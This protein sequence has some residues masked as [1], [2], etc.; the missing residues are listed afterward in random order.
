MGKTK[1]GK[2]RQ[3]SASIRKEIRF[4]K[5]EIENSCNEFSEARDSVCY[6]LLVGST[7]IRPALVDKIFDELRSQEFNC[8][9]LDVIIH[10]GGGDIDAAYN[11]ALLFRRY[12]NEN[13]TFIIPRWAKS[14]ATLLICS[15]NEILMTPV[16]EIGP[17]D[18]QI[19]EMNPLENRLERFSPLHIESTLQLIRDEFDSGNQD[20]AD[21]LLQRLQF[22]MTLGSFRKSL[23]LG[24]DYL[25][26][27]LKS[28]MLEENKD[29]AKDIAESLSTGYANHSWCITIEEAQNLGLKA[30]ELTGK[31]LDLVWT[32]YKHK[33]K[34]DDLRRKLDKA[35]MLA[36][37]KK[38]PPELLDKLQPEQFGDL[39]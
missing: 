2:S 8:K 27:L 34:L 4:I 21:G 7:E 12:G 15:G 25:E 28:R 17:L 14:A 13:L 20:L 35:K 10:S 18:P 6:P 19:T 3:K 36:E 30:K 32:I 23:D 37:L 33:R 24:K 38:L 29:K 22:P 39:H 1:S 11:L 9:K 31:E 16:A 5:K 26:K